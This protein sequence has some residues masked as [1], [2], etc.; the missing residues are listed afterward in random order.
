MTLAPKHNIK[1]IDMVYTKDMDWFYHIVFT[2]RD[3]TN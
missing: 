2:Y 3:G 1:K